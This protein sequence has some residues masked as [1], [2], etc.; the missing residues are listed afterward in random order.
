M[1]LFSFAII[2]PESI[3]QF[4]AEVERTNSSLVFAED[5][6]YLSS[7]KQFDDLFSLL[8]PFVIVYALDRHAV[9]LSVKFAR[10]HDLHL[11][12]RSGGNSNLGWGVCNGCVV[13]D[14]S[15]MDGINIIPQPDYKFPLLRIEPGV[16]NKLLIQTLTPLGLA[17]PNGD[18][19][20]VC[21]GGYA[22]GG[23]FSLQMRSLGLNIDN[24]IEIEFVNVTGHAMTCSLSESPHF[25]W[26]LRG[27][28]GINFG[29][30]TS[31]LYQSHQLPSRLI[32]GALI[33]PMEM[34]KQVTELYYDALWDE[35]GQ[36]RNIPFGFSLCLINN[37]PETNGETVLVMSGLYFS[38]NLTMGKSI[39]EPFLKLPKTTNYL[40]EDSFDEIMWKV[41]EGPYFDNM[42]WTMPD[43]MIDRLTRKDFV[44]FFLGVVE[45]ESR[46]PANLVVT[47]VYAPL[48]GKVNQV[49]PEAAAFPHRTSGGNFHMPTAWTD[50]RDEVRVVKWLDD[51]LFSTSRYWTRSRLFPSMNNIPM[52]YI[53]H[54]SITLK[55]FTVSYYD[56]NY[57]ELL[58]LKKKYDP[59]N[60][61][62]NG[63]P[64]F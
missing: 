54:P 16:N 14:L 57:P 47:W 33:W 58:R 15:R 48:G 38:S 22:T 39:L 1:A 21:M 49:R 27:G 30:V 6:N 45:W 11:S 19:P 43:A 50:P 9:S 35:N 8:K 28:G 26:A 10:S 42:N 61:F 17:I 55:N 41:M 18:C 34:A 5:A 20:G 62:R 63:Q 32:G 40:M 25:F 23:G 24:I 3:R 51:V 29:I 64:L 56:T 31:L 36:E 59:M 2:P 53:N 52:S 46:K 12:V 7:V 37:I 60:F 4:I 44:D 13:V